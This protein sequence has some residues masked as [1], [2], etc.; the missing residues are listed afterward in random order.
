[1]TSIPVPT[2]SGTPDAAPAT[3]SPDAAQRPPGR[4]GARRRPHQ[5]SG[6]T[7]GGRTHPLLE[8]LATLY[9]G[10]FG[11]PPKP[12]KR[13]IFQD[14][15]A[16]HPEQFNKEALKAALAL[17]T[18]SSRY[19][20]VVATGMPRHDLGNLAVEDMAPEHVYQALVEVFRRRQ[21]RAREDL[22]P[23]VVKRMAEAF[24]NSGLSR[25]DYAQ[26]MRGKDEGINAVLDE[27]LAQAAAHAARD[28]AQLRAFEASGQTIEAFADMY[29]LDPAVAARTIERARHRLAGRPCPA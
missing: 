25:E 6:Q 9:P 17:H 12:L 26:R 29:G 10:L 22:T 21:A 8:Q 27:A 11:D 14:L 28:E 5:A 7:A 13:G 1:M 15:L 3:A 2:E 24:E 20:T 16:A 4:G 19:L 23:K 18:R